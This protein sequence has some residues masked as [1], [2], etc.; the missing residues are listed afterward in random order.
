MLRDATEFR[1][2]LAKEAMAV[3]ASIRVSVAND[4]G[5][6]VGDGQMA[7]HPALL[8]SSL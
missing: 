5:I 7:I 4:V 2:P 1:Q 8:N 6:G 3:F